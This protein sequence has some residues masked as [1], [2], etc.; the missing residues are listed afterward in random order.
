MNLALI[1]P[2][3]SIPAH[4]TRSGDQGEHGPTGEEHPTPLSLVLPCDRGELASGNPLPDGAFTHSEPLDDLGNTQ[5]HVGIIGFHGLSSTGFQG[6]RQAVDCP[7]TSHNIHY[8]YPVFHRFIQCLQGF[9][10]CMVHGMYTLQSNLRR[11]GAR[12][13]SLKNSGAGVLG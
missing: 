9:S 6:E 12:R 8:V 4:R 3:E 13:V 11:K 1:L 2:D 7:T 10:W 5:D